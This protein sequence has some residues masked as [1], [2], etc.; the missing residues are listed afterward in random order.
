MANA[1]AGVLLSAT[2][3]TLTEG[4]SGRYTVRL[5]ARPSASVTVAITSSNAAVTVDDTDAGTT[6]V[7]NALTFTTERLEPRR[8][9]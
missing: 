2:A 6:G 4:G 7:Q 9:G 5:A 8:R 3:L 1:T